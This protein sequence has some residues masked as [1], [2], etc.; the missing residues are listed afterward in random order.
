[1]NINIWHRWVL[2]GDLTGGEAEKM[3]DGDGYPDGWWG[4][5]GFSYKP[6]RE[7]TGKKIIFAAGM[8]TGMDIALTDG[9]GDGNSNPRPVCI[10]TCRVWL[11]K[12]YVYFYYLKITNLKFKILRIIKENN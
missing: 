10:H 8:G 11:V 6:I 12:M 9:D 5:D 1:M 7:E 4:G 3:G 2:S